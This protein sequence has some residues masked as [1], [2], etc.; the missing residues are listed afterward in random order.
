MRIMLE[1]SRLLRGGETGKLAALE[2]E[3]LAENARH[4]DWECTE[5]RMAKTRDGRA[6]YLHCLPADITGV[7]CEAGEVAAP[8]FERHRLDTYREAG[9]K[10]FVIAA[11]ILATR[12]REPASVLFEC[13]DREQSRRPL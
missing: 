6:L 8:V 5:E 9:H 7:S 12:F 1:R 3:A 2:K 13:V 11:M 4:R 10:P